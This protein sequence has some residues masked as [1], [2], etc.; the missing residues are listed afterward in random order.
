VWKALTRRSHTHITSRVSASGERGVEGLRLTNSR[1]ARGA[2]AKVRSWSHGNVR[3]MPGIK[4][5]R[6]GF[7]EGPVDRIHWRF[8]QGIK[9]AA[10]ARGEF[11][12]IL[13]GSWP[14]G[15]RS[16]SELKCWL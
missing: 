5:R 7:R 12:T 9:G 3:L 8:Q 13:C 4:L 11:R 16:A 1:V 2:C 14:E 15:R 6:V 10:S